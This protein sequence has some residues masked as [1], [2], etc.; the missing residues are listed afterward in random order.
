M[1]PEPPA[2]IDDLIAG[3][4]RETAKSEGA[5]IEN[6]IAALILALVPGGLV[7]YLGFNGGGFFPGTV[8]F[9]CVIVIQLLI[10]RILLADHPFEGV[11]RGVAFAGVA[12]AGFVAWILLSGLWSHAHDRTL[13]EFDRGLLYL[14][15]FLL[16]GFVARSTSRIPWMVR[17]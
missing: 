5:R 11:S 9:A 17:R 2:A 3:P 7:V 14:S 13:I 8:G 1:G 12:L 6:R 10:V 15:V 4:R 16:F